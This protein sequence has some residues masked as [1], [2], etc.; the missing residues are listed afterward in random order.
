VGVPPRASLGG[1]SFPYGPR[2]GT[3][4]STP[5]LRVPDAKGILNRFPGWSLPP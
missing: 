2:L 1:N 3:S 4:D 5:H